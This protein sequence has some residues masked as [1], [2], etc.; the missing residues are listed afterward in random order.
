M[1][2]EKRNT[3]KLTLEK[4]L[5][6]KKAERPDDAFWQRFDRD[7]EKKIVRSVVSREPRL[8]VFRGWVK[9]HAGWVAGVGCAVFLAAVMVTNIEDSALEPERI[10]EE[11]SVWETG[12]TQRTED[13]APA[14]RRTVVA[15]SLSGS[16][17][18]F[19]IEVLSS[20]R[21]GAG[22]GASLTF[23]DRG[24]GGDAGAYY[25]ADQLSSAD[26]GWSGER[27]PF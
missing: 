26:Q 2:D 6:L 7:L 27:L 25:V 4:L 8:Q 10:V 21:G 22:S 15:P 23:V 14:G 18:S 12:E 9:A 19:V 24:K 20:G 16:D 13:V 17:N 11:A 1:A 3:E 5:S